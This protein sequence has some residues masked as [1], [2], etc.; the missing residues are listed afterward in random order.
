MAF[1]AAVPAA[2]AA[3]GAGTA[4]AGTATAVAPLLAAGGTSAITAAGMPAVGATLLSGASL[5]SLLAYGGAALGALGALGSAKAQSDA[6][7]ANADLAEQQAKA[8]NAATQDATL[9]LSRERARTIGSQT[10]LYAA[11]GIAPSSGSP[12][13]VMADTAR[14]YERDILNTGYSG[15]SAVASSM[16][17]AKT[18]RAGAKNAMRAGL[19]DAGGTILTSGLK[20]RYSSLLY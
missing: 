3:A 7:E 14:E 20:R 16:L 2:M 12:L 10:A 19:L 17:E 8:Q 11:G 5:G 6:M 1:L 15:S 18:Y 9:K 13:D 4:A